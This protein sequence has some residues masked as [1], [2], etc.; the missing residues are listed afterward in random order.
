MV[1]SYQRGNTYGININAN[2]PMGKPWLPHKKRFFRLTKED[3]ELIRKNKQTEFYKKALKRLK[4]DNVEVYILGDTLVI[5]YSTDKYFFES[6]AI[7]KILYVL[8]VLYFKKVRKVKVVVKEKNIPIS[9]FIF[10]GKDINNFLL[11]KGGCQLYKWYR[12][13]RK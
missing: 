13:V 11:G 8:K 2:F 1:V 5:E 10:D 3:I 12:S 6:V 9:E 4:Y 7:K